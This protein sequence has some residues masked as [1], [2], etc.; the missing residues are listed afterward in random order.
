MDKVSGGTVSSNGWGV[1]EY[2]RLK[3]AASQHLKAAHF[4]GGFDDV[5]LPQ[6]L[7]AA[8][9]IELHLLAYVAYGGASA[10]TAPGADISNL[11]QL[12]EPLSPQL[13]R[14]LSDAF[15]EHHGGSLTRQLEKFNHPFIQIRHHLQLP[16]FYHGFDLVEF[17]QLARFFGRFEPQL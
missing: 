9:S 11:S 2:G 17:M 13:H 10:V 5:A 8:L 4:L 14:A 1:E 12:V 6:L 16:D 15:S 7:N 3:S